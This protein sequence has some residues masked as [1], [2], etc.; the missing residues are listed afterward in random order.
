MA[1][2]NFTG[3]NAAVAGNLT[4]ADEFHADHPSAYY[5][6]IAAT[7]YAAAN[8]AAAS[9]SSVTIGPGTKTFVLDRLVGWV[10]GTPVYITEE[11]A[12]VANAL[13]G[14][15]TTDQDPTTREI[16]VTIVGFKGSGTFTG[17]AVSAI[18]FI[19]S[20]AT[21]PP[22]AVADG[23]TSASDEDGVRT[24]FELIRQVK[25]IAAQPTPPGSP[26]PDDKYLAV[27]RGGVVP[28]GAW[29]GNANN[30]ATWNGATWDFETPDTGEQTRT[31]SGEVWTYTGA[32][33]LQIGHKSPG[34]APLDI[35]LAPA[36]LTAFSW[37][38]DGGRAAKLYAVVS[39]TIGSPPYTLTVPNLNGFEPSLAVVIRN[40]S[41]ATLEIN[42]AGGGLIDGAPFVNV[43][44]A[45]TAEF[46]WWD[47]ASEWKQFH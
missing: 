21:P 1:E 45:T 37:E 24:V 47:P 23:G 4:A 9:G 10:A 46:A 5:N 17:W 33:W 18:F 39:G 20:A 22:Y 30:W 8:R 43:P 13:W 26:I 14:H 44:D 34:I 27:R 11:G 28:S 19:A 42:V 32:E 2:Q 41:G 40:N 16:E 15:M 36:T 25:V 12:P 6:T 38:T 3:Y 35:P 31:S 7:A 29:A